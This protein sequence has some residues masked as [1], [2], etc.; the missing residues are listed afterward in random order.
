MIIQGGFLALDELS[1]GIFMCHGEDE[2]GEFHMT[3]IGF[4]FFNIEFLIYK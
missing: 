3:T 1:L 2:L 4:L